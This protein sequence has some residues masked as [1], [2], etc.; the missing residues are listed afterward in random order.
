[1]QET[2]RR[3]LGRGGTH[4]GQGKEQPAAAADLTLRGLDPEVLEQLRALR[5]LQEWAVR[6]CRP[7]ICRRGIRRHHVCRY[8]IRGTALLRP[9][10]WPFAAGFLGACRAARSRPG[11]RAGN[12]RPGIAC[13][14]IAPPGGADRG[15][16]FD[17]RSLSLKL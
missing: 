12:R 9:G 4:R 16:A 13:P 3:L 17:A 11:I 2:T 10:S 14:D 6:A 7:G 1:M 15:P 5:A 8:G